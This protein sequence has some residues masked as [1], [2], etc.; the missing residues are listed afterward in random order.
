MESDEGI[1]AWDDCLGE[2]ELIEEITRLKVDDRDD[3]ND[4]G[5]EGVTSELNLSVETDIYDIQDDLKIGPPP[6]E[7]EEETEEREVELGMECD[8][9]EVVANE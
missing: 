7:N 8:E 4:D 1:M 2:L 5:G 6:R 3:C 9:E